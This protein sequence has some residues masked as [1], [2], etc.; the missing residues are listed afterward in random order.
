MATTQMLGA[1]IKRREDPE[2]LTGAG[3]F[4]ADMEVPNAAHAAVLHSPHAHA[5]ILSIKTTAAAKMPGVIR[6]FV[7]SDD[8]VAKMN[9]LVCIFKPSGVES[10]FPPHPYGLPGA[11]TALATDRVRYVGEWIAVVIA[12]SRQ[13]IGRASCREKV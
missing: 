7:G 13:Q 4:T 2:L 11:Q 8:V 3:K 10:H 1:S 6:V 9:P 12:E 5:K